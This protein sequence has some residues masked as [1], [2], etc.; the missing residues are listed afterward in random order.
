[1]KGQIGINWFERGTGESQEDAMD[2]IYERG[3]A[4]MRCPIPSKG[5]IGGNGC[6]Q[7]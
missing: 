1:M 5:E 7:G 2:K 4:F 6:A 3:I